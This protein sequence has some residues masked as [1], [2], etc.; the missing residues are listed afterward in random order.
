MLKNAQVKRLA[1]SLGAEIRGVQLTDMKSSQ[2]REI[3]DLL[4]EHQVLFF[5]DQS[6][7]A[8]EHVRFGELFGELEAHPHLMHSDVES[9]TDAA[10]ILELKGLVATRTSEIAQD[11]MASCVLGRQQFSNV[12]KYF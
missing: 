1:H 4:W 7:T 5:P 9:E 10:K 11:T 3:E 6:L 8:T 12:N 2:A